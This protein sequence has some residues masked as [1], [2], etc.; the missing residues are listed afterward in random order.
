MITLNVSYCQLYQNAYWFQTLS[1]VRPSFSSIWDLFYFTSLRRLFLNV[2]CYS[3]KG[4]SRVRA[5]PSSLDFT[6]TKRNEFAGYFSTEAAAATTTTS[7]T[8]KTVRPLVPSTRMHREIT[9]RLEWNL[10][11][12]ETKFFLRKMGYRSLFLLFVPSSNFL[13]SITI[14]FYNLMKLIKSRFFFLSTYFPDLR[15]AESER[16]WWWL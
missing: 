10:F 14:S 8:S 16:W 7:L 5:E 6:T 9:F 11:F 3:R 13:V 12:K 2:T 15:L 4:L 1:F